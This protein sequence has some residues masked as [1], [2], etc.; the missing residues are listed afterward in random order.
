MTDRFVDVCSFAPLTAPKSDVS[1]HYTPVLTSLTDCCL[2]F[3]VDFELED[4][5]KEFS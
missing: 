3:S 2:F 1:V 4:A 5:E